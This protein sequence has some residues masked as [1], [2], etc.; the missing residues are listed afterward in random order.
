MGYLTGGSSKLNGNGQLIRPHRKGLN[1]ETINN[2]NSHD[3]RESKMK[4]YHPFFYSSLIKYALN[5]IIDVFYNYRYTVG[6]YYIIILYII[7]KQMQMSHDEILP[8]VGKNSPL[9]HQ[10]VER[11]SN[12]RKVN[13]KKLKERRP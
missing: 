4:M 1:K 6:I 10:I 2:N 13:Q 7:I 8:H 9:I 12:Q 5:K 3:L 11:H